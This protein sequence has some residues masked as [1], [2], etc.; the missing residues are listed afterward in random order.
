MAI[1]PIP[2]STPFQP[3]N[4]N[5]RTQPATPSQDPSNTQDLFLPSEPE[6]GIPNR[7]AML[8]AAGISRAGKNGAEFFKGVGD[9]FKDAW[10]AVTHPGETYD[11]LKGL[12]K[13]V[14]DDPG[15]AAREA[16]QAG[17]E[18]AE[19]IKNNSSEANSRLLGQ[20]VPLPG[21]KQ[22]AMLGVAAR[23]GKAAN[24]AGKV[25]AEAGK[26]GEAAGK[27]GKVAEDAGKAGKTAEKTAE[28]NGRREIPGKPKEGPVQEQLQK[29]EDR[30]PSNPP[31]PGET[32]AENASRGPKEHAEGSV[33]KQKEALE[34]ERANQLK[35]AQNMK[36]HENSRRI[37]NPTPK[38]KELL[39]SEGKKI[40][41]PKALS[42]DLDGNGIHV[43]PQGTN[44]H[45]QYKLENGELKTFSKDAAATDLQKEAARLKLLADPKFRKQLAEQIESGLKL[46]PPAD[47][48]ALQKAKEFL[49]YLQ[50]LDL[51]K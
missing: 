19:K 4:T 44:V 49:T 51:P 1:N 5:Q 34:A 6:T 17:K 30:R 15:G 25:V 32:N 11:A 35:D 21:V 28:T 50:A 29:M 43:K 7:A 27:A 18:L 23:F 31:G 38:Q 13:R 36:I 9:Q 45:I 39:E 3:L 24:L 42:T 14:S 8:A 47:P 2:S 41:N 12:V 20:N 16:G 48:T 26:A 10:E 37:D 22:L 46:R 33:N 40:E